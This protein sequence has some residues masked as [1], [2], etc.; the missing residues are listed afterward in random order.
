MAHRCSLAWIPST[1]AS[2]SS[3]DSIGHGAP[4]FTNVSWRA[5]SK[6]ADSL[7]PFAMQAAS[8]PSDYYGGSV[9]SPGQQPTAGLPA[10]APAARQEGQPREGSHVH[11]TT[12]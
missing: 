3:A 8:P 1:R 7:P 12:A 2:A 9:P 10:A 6:P 11:E 4:V 5:S